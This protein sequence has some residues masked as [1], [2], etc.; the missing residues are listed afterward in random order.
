MT[1]GH[2][3]WSGEVRCVVE[4]GG[5]RLS[6]TKWA[7][8]TEKERKRE[9]EREKKWREMRAGKRWIS[10]ASRSKPDLIILADRKRER[11][12]NILERE[13]ERKVDQLW[14]FWLCR[15]SQPLTDSA[16]TK[17]TQQASDL[18]FV[19]FFSCFV[20]LRRLTH[21]SWLNQTHASW[22][23]INATVFNQN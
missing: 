10:G 20:F 9:R 13:R 18:F 19:S 22:L 23:S 12:R 8:K 15:A 21:S 17:K 16:A 6:I 5:R 7:K 11:E 2:W 4:L 3:P 14:V 1:E